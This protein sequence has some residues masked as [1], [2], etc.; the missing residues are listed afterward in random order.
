MFEVVGLGDQNGT[1]FELFFKFG[2]EAVDTGLEHIN[3]D[4][5]GGKI[6]AGEDVT[7]EKVGIR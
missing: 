2:L 3:V 5:V 1:F 6:V 7:M 4:N